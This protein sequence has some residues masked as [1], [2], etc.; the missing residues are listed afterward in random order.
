MT[1]T[2]CPDETTL[3]EVALDGQGPGMFA[4]HLQACPSCRERFDEIHA[5]MNGLDLLSSAT[6]DPSA[7]SRQLVLQ[8]HPTS[9]GKYYVLGMIEGR[10]GMMVYRGMHTVIQSDEVAIFLSREAWAIDAAARSGFQTACLPLMRFGHAAIAPAVDLGFFE[11]RPYLMLGYRPGHSWD[12]VTTSRKFS[13][14][15]AATIGATL[16][17]ALAEAHRSGM[18][19]GSLGRNSVRFDESGQPSICDFG[20]SQVVPISI[21]N[22]EVSTDLEALAALIHELAPD[23]EINVK[24]A[25]EMT[26]C[27]DRQ[28]GRRPLIARF[29]S[30]LRR[31]RPGP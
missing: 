23:V 18:V 12:R 24:D 16:A 5:L 20:V 10:E 4:E 17:R 28:A 2:P 26:H 13:R 25:N 29:Q 1:K 14:A 31:D 30:W 22:Q 8:G 7:A 15:E 19:H 6:I 27:F 11:E 3:T 9:L 21:G